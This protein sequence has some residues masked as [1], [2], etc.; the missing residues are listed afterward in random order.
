MDGNRKS[1][2]EIKRKKNIFDE[3]F[4]TNDVGTTMHPHA[5]MGM[6]TQ[7]PFITTITQNG[8]DTY[9]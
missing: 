2:D 9:M 8:L 5:R 4:S 6:E 1:V 3:S 7:T